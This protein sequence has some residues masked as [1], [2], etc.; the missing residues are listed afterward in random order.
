MERCLV[1]PLRAR[2][3]CVLAQPRLATSGTNEMQA[4]QMKRENEKTKTERTEYKYNQETSEWATYWA[5]ARM[6]LV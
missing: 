3:C 4:N 1:R 2:S 6:A 5:P